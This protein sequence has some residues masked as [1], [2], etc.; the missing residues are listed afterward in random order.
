MGIPSFTL[1]QQTS[2][3]RARKMGWQDLGDP[4]LNSKSYKYKSLLQRK[5]PQTHHPLLESASEDCGA[6]ITP[7]TLSCLAPQDAGKIDPRK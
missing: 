7:Q 5:Y 3:L 1:S 2:S 6:G 4:S